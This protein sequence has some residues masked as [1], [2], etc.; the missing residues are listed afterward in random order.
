MVTKRIV[1]V[2]SLCGHEYARWF[3]EA[4]TYAHMNEAHG[5]RFE[6]GSLRPGD[7]PRWVSTVRP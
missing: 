5:M 6:P 4:E 2:C 3:D 1:A 7:A